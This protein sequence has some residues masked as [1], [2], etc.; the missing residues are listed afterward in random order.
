MR[1]WVTGGA[2][3]VG[4]HLV[5][6]LL[7]DGH[8]VDALDD[9]SGG[10]LSNLAEARGRQGFSFH[11][12]DVL[13]EELVA[14]AERH[15]PDVIVHLAGRVIRP[16][17]LP[18]PVEEGRLTV[19]GALRVL[20]AARGV[21]S[22]V[23][24]VVHAT[25][26]T[27]QAPAT[28]AEVS[29]WTVV[30]HLRLQREAYGVETVCVALTNVYGPRQQVNGRGPLVAAMVDNA[31]VG[32]PLEVHGGDHRRD[33]LFVD[34]AVDA[35]ARC[36]ER[37]PHGVVPVGSGIVVAPSEVAA[38]VAGGLADDSTPTVVTGPA[39]TR[40]AARPPWPTEPARQLLGWEPWT[41]LEDGIA[42]TVMARLAETH[43]S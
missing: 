16:G 27:D 42:A 11:Q 21:G 5:D 41:P 23:V 35:L 37:R 17:G 22:C 31:A 19:L 24:G 34:D 36:V 32:R 6:R 2:G 7:A 40:D 4:S 1:V 3:F 18:D 9:L 43:G 8:R 20:E 15:E 33:L 29:A 39:R 26:D 38:L 30:D 13:A 14:L 25:P 12:I 10:R 28:P